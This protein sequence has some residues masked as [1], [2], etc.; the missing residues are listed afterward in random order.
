MS[1]TITFPEMSNDPDAEGVVATWFANTGETVK[2]G[3]VIA[4]VMVDK[5][6]VDVEAPIGGTITCLVEEEGTAKQ[7]QEIARID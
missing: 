6:S 7:G 2:A 3:Q 4:E 5:V 1:E